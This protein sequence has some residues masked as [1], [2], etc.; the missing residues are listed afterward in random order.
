[1]VIYKHIHEKGK[2]PESKKINY[3]HKREP[4]IQGGHNP[5]PL[6]PC[7]AKLPVHTFQ[8]SKD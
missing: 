5:R 1:M 4:T 2:E 8:K 7:C 3:A 6:D